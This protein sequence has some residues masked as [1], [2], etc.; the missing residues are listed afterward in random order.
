[1]SRWVLAL[2]IL[3]LPALLDRLRR[4]IGTDD[5]LVCGES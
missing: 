1:M 2:L 5:G 3:L 4:N